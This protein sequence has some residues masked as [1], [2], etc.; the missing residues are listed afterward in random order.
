MQ[1]AYQIFNTLPP[2][3]V[4]S[5]RLGGLCGIDFVENARF[6]LQADTVVSLAIDVEKKVLCP[7][8]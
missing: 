7:V 2:G 6:V 8:R 1:E 5:Q 4:E 3:E